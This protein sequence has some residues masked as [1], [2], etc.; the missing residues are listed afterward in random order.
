M[1][2]LAGGA[3][4][5]ALFGG[6]YS[7]FEV[8]RLEKE[9][10]AEYARLRELQAE[11]V[12]LQARADSLEKDSATLERV[13]REKYGLIREGERLYRFV[14]STRPKPDST[15]KKRR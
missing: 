4:Y 10:A 2:M 13:A 12:K 15:P 3:I 5:F 6:D 8:R 11:M 1:I 7:L 9:R 14:D